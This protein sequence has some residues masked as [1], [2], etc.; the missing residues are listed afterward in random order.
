[1]NFL[2]YRVISVVVSL[3]AGLLLGIA[4][5]LAGEWDG[6]IAV[7]LHL[8]FSG[9]W[10]WAA[11]AFLVGYFSRS[12]IESALLSSCGLT[13][14][15]IAYYLYKHISPLAPV[16]MEYG[17]PSEG[18]SSR[19]ITWGVMA[20]L[21]GA[22]VGLLG[23]LARMPGVRGLLFRL[24]VPFV[25]FYETSM[26]LTMEADRQGP[27]VGATWQVIRLVAV[28]VALAL[29]VHAVRSGWQARHPRQPSIHIGEPVTPASRVRSGADRT[30]E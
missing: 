20:F 15:V 23:Y 1:M 28:A 2:R 25:A 9:G 11:Y 10:S 12:K 4:G 14:G 29:V 27:M 8:T 22:P 5:P 17:A 18:L 13:I 21:L 6:P 19:I 16:G 26:R 30:S 7:A 3:V 24:V